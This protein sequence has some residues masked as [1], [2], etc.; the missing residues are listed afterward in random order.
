MLGSNEELFAE[1]PLWWTLP[2]DTLMALFRDNRHSG[3]LYRS[4]SSDNGRNW[5]K[6]IQDQLPRC[7]LQTTRPQI[8]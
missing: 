3:F 8:E 6:P 5:N 2:D 4:F 1:E 7:H